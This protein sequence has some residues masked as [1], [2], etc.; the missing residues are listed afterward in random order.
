MVTIK[1]RVLSWLTYFSHNCGKYR[2]FETI[3][4]IGI[5]RTILNISIS[6]SEI[7]L[8]KCDLQKLHGNE[9]TALRLWHV[10]R[11][12]VRIDSFG[13]LRIH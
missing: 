4:E 13:I 6:K 1:E 5:W 2:N 8:R 7:K 12:K 3:L 9:Q 11:S 10:A